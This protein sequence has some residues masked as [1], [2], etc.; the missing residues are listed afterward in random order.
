MKRRAK[1]IK[2]AVFISGMT[3]MRVVLVDA[4]GLVDLIDA[5]TVGVLCSVAAVILP[6]FVPAKLILF[7]CTAIFFC[8]FVLLKRTAGGTV[9]T[10]WAA[11]APSDWTGNAWAWSL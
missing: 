1:W 4:L 7:V 9:G 8:Y 2:S 5:V 6:A 11:S 3:I 10:A